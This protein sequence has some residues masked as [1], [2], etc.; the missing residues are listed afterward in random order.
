MFKKAINCINNNML[1]LYKK[2]AET[3]HLSEKVTN[4]LPERFKSNVT[5]ASYDKGQLVLRANT[6]PL[7]TELRYLLPDLR[8]NLR[9]KESLYTLIDIKII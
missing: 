8:D 7:R 2:T 4:H 6:A 1:E 5:I 9:Q 3:E